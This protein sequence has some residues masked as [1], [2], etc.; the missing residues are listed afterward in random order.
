MSFNWSLFCRSSVNSPLSNRLIGWCRC[1][2]DHI[3]IIS[4]SLLRDQ[5]WLGSS[6]QLEFLLDLLCDII[7]R[8]WLLDLRFV[9]IT[10]M[11]VIRTRMVSIFACF[12]ILFT[13]S[14]NQEISHGG[15]FFHVVLNYFVFRPQWYF[16]YS[17][18]IL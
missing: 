17:T 18:L 1:L 15:I 7:V 3:S 4:A 5:W 6:V 9:S 11:I 8:L 13:P 10:T 2:V 14:R 16:V 12:F